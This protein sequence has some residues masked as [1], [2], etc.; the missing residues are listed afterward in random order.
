M[1]K[2]LIITFSGNKY[3]LHKQLK[4]WCVEAEQSMNGLIIGLIKNHLKENE[5]SN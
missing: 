5:K 1:Q 4:K 2:R 3:Q